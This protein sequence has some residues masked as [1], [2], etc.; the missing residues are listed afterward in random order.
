[1]LI[2]KILADIVMLILIVKFFF[3]PSAKELLIYIK[4]RKN[5]IRII[6]KIVS[7]NQYKESEGLIRYYYIIEYFLD[8]KAYRQELLKTGFGKP[9][10]GQEI[11]IVCD[12]N[13]PNKIFEVTIEELL[14]IIAKSLLALGA[15][16]LIV[17]FFVSTL[18]S[19]W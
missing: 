3:L 17:Y 4:V 16:C 13:N 10:V 15:V 19:A 2:I 7:F 5:G 14:G 9:V 6:S 8:G 1:M 11:K 18:V 12:E